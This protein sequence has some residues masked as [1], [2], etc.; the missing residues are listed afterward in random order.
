MEPN[1]F[2]GRT[3][4][5]IGGHGA[6]GRWC[7]HLF[8]Q[9]GCEVRS[10]DIG[11]ELSNEDVAEWAE[12]V[13]LA[14]PIGVTA[15]VLESVGPKLRTQKLL[16]ELTSVKTPFERH[17][18][19]LACEVL[20]LHPMFSPSIRSCE[21]QSCVVTRH[22]PAATGDSLLALLHDRNISLV[23]MSVEE[24]DRTMAVI[25]GLTHFQAIA[26]AHCMNALGFDLQ[27]SLSVASP[28]YRLRLSMIGRIIAQDPRL[29]AEIQMHNPYVSP[30]IEAL[31]SSSQTLADLIARKDLEA[32]ITEWGA[33]KKA[34]GEFQH[35]ALAESTELIEALRAIVARKKDSVAG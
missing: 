7:V 26:A 24:H 8:E 12:I 2:S 10:S 34:F 4:G 27:K 14:V 29:Y 20:S 11:T 3:V 17:L 16:V 32:F 25:Q 23:E 5:I 31:A 33:S 18:S 6:F 22:R 15:P 9:A 13:V 19:A 30:V 35:E 21:G 28:V 1:A